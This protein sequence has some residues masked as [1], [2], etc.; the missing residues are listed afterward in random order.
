MAKYICKNIK[1]RIAE[2]KKHRMTFEGAIA[3]I[4]E[5]EKEVVEKK[6]LIDGYYQKIYELMDKVDE[7]NEVIDNLKNKINYAGM[8]PSKCVCTYLDIHQE[9]EC[10]ACC[11][12]MNDYNFDCEELNVTEKTE[13]FM[14]YDIS[15]EN[16][17]LLYVDKNF[18]NKKLYHVIYLSFD[19]EVLILV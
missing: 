18:C 1:E 4:Y 11:G 12:C 6:E 5:L 7:L 8:K 14:A 2:A 15:V 17:N 10:E 3:K 19:G 16:E 13:T 9:C